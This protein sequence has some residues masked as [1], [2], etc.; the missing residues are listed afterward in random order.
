MNQSINQLK[1]IKYYLS[2]SKYVTSVACALNILS[3]FSWYL[4]VRVLVQACL[5]ACARSRVRACVCVRAKQ[6]KKGKKR[7]RIGKMLYGPKPLCTHILDCTL[8]RDTQGY[9]VRED[10][11]GGEVTGSADSGGLTHTVRLSLSSLSLSSLSFTC[12][13]T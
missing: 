2:A 1:K 10:T 5:G 11:C 13:L 12:F 9:C 6:R 4:F 8:H 3:I 7:F